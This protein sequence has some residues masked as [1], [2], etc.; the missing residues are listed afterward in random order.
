MGCESYDT[1]YLKFSEGDD[2]LG[3]LCTFPHN[4]GSSLSADRVRSLAYLGAAVVLLRRGKLEHGY[5]PN[6]L[7]DWVRS[8][9]DRSLTPH[10]ET[11]EAEKLREALDHI[12]R[13][14]FGSR[15]PTN[16]TRWIAARAMSALNGDDKWLD[17][18]RPHG[19][20]D[21][22]HLPPNAK[23]GER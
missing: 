11:D 2:D 6:C 19:Y 4:D 5:L 15:S 20:H 12:I 17:A 16:R 14:A 21:R 8:E 9:I 3:C 22:L 18:T 10:K 13:V 1:T 7:P 23:Y